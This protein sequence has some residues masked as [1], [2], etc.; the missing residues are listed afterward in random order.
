MRYSIFLLAST[1]CFISLVTAAQNAVDS[2]LYFKALTKT[3]GVPMPKLREGE[4][5]IRV[6]VK[7]ALKYG[8]A[9]DLYVTT[10]KRKRIKLKKIEISSNNRKINNQKLGFLSTISSKRTLSGSDPKRGYRFAP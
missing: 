9:H 8:Q 7:I 3:I 4:Y 6:W 5:Q 1:F 2:A 10:V